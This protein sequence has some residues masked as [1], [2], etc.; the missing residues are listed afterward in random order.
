[1]SRVQRIVLWAECVLL[2]DKRQARG[3]GV[4][5]C[6]PPLSS[7]SAVFTVPAQVHADI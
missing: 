6:R 4:L 7:V 1:M 2:P 5:A 3:G